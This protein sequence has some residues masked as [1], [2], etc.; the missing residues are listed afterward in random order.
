MKQFQSRAYVN[1][2]KG[3]KDVLVGLWSEYGLNGGVLYS[4]S[5]DGGFRQWSL[6][7]KEII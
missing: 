2:L 5:Q 4:L 7:E 1:R 3:H 6:I